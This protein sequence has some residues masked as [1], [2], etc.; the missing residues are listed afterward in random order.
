MGQNTFLFLAVYLS[1]LFPLVPFTRDYSS[2]FI[3][4][5]GDYGSLLNRTYLINWFIVGAVIG[6]IIVYVAP[7]LSAALTRMRGGRTLKFQGIVLTFL[8]LAITAFLM[9]VLR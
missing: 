2:W 9:Q 7:R 5:W 6:S 1:T 8:L 3:S 4:W